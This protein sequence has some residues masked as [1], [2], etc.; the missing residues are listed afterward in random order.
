MCT[1][2]ILAVLSSLIKAMI[3][4]AS[5]WK[6]NAIGL[7]HPSASGTTKISTRHHATDSQYL[8]LVIKILVFDS[9]TG[10]IKY[11]LGHSHTRTPNG[12]FD[13]VILTADEFQNN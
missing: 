6:K 5:A 2:F 3:N 10:Q 13:L 7:E 9:K 11:S 4:G 12:F 1:I 8:V